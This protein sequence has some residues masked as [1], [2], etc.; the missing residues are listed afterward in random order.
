MVSNKSL[1]YS[2]TPTPS[3]DISTGAIV[4]ICI[5][6]VVCIALCFLMYYFCTMYCFYI[7]DP[8]SRP[9]FLYTHNIEERDCGTIACV[10]INRNLILCCCPSLKKTVETTNLYQEG[11]SNLNVTQT[12]SQFIYAHEMENL[13]GQEIWPCDLKIGGHDFWPYGQNEVLKGVK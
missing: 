9:E 8:R 7:S 2:S 10:N 1:L 3:V 12:S 4:G 11:S 5:G 13:M 6:I